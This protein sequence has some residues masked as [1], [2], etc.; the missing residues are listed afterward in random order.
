[1]KQHTWQCLLH[2]QCSSIF[3]LLNDENFFQVEL[4]VS[5]VTFIYFS[6]FLLAKALFHFSIFKKN[7]GLFVHAQL[8]L[9][10][11]D[12][13]DYNLPGSPVQRIS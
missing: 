10:L 12:H 7:Y 4:G 9:S 6:F 1:M 13:M 11:C 3:A 2:R 8:C 5:N